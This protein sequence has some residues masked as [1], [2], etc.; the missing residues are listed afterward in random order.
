MSGYICSK[1]KVHSIWRP[2]ERDEAGCPPQAVGKCPPDSLRGQVLTLI[3][4]IRLD[5][6]KVGGKI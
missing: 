1:W 3:A 6:R 2:I 4:P 5:V